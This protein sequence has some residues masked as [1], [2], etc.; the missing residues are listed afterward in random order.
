MSAIYRN[1]DLG[2]TGQVVKNSAGYV[3]GWY[4]GNAAAAVRY[5]KL[6]DKATAATE[7]DTPKLTL[8]IPASA[9]VN[10][11][12]NGGDAPVAISFD[13]GISL[14]ATTGVADNNTVAPT[15]NDVVINLLYS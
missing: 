9:A 5:V 8:L 13:N 7:T 6:Y 2:V 14:R 10:V 11:G 3:R 1:L 15:A 4:V 12:L